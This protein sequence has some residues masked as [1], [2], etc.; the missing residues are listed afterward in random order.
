MKKLY[1]S[2]TNKV[3]GGVLGG[4][5]EYTEVDPVV[6]RLAFAFMVLVTGIFP[7]VIAYLVALAIVPVHPGHKTQ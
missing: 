5:G 6:L 4:L 1:R 2:R 3:W 7:G